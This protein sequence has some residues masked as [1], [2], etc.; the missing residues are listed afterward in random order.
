VKPVI[1]FLLAISFDLAAMNIPDC[2]PQKEGDQFYFTAESIAVFLYILTVA[3]VSKNSFIINT[4]SSAWSVVALNDV[5][6]NIFDIN[7]R[8]YFLEYLFFALS[9]IVV[10]WKIYCYYHPIEKRLFRRKFAGFKKRVVF[11]K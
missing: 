8:G 4:I 3:V 9:F 7:E 11:R 1:I 6:D 2:L 5:S 10:C